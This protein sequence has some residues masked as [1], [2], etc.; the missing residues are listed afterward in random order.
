MNEKEKMLQGY[1]Y[2][3]SDAVLRKDRERAKD[4]LFAYHQLLPS[5]RKERAELL[6]QLIHASGNFHIET[7]F[8]FD[9]GYNIT[10]GKEFYANHNCVMLDCAPITIGDH[11]LFGPNVALFCASHPLHPETRRSGLEFALPITIGNDVWIGGSSVI[12]PGV[13]IGDGAVIASGSVVTKDV[14]DNVVVA[15]NPA[16]I[17]R[18]ISEADR[19]YYYKNQKF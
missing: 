7:P 11:V 12:N 14:P 9:Y 15:G 19:N 13:S 6:K 3:A 4:I 16:R 17:L 2:D 18:K 10:I 5:Q 8:A 1:P